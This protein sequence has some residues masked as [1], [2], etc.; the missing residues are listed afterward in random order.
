MNDKGFKILDE[1]AAKMIHLKVPPGKAGMSQTLPPE[2]TSTY[3]V[4]KVRILVG[5]FIRRLKTWIIANEIPVSGLSH[6]DDILTIC[7][8][9]CNFKDSICFLK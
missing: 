3:D 8:A 1:C 7:V 9:F 4:A 2:I 5:Q 6:A